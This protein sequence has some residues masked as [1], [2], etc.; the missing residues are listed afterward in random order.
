MIQLIKHSECH[1]RVSDDAL[2]LFWTSRAG[3]CSGVQ[4]EAEA[5]PVRAPQR[6][7]WDED[8]RRGLDHADPE[9]AHGVGARAAE[10]GT[11]AA[12]RPPGEEAAQRNL[13]QGAEAGEAGF[14]LTSEL[15]F[16]VLFGHA[17]SSA[18]DL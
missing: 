7:L 14:I 6:V 18:T 16:P 12:G 17:S 4:A 11:R 13:H 1:Q 2:F 10:G 9:P 3:R 15:L 8:G 5:R